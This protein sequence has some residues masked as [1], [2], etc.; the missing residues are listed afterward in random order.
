MLEEM[1]KKKPKEK[2]KDV[3]MGMLRGVPMG[4]SSRN[5]TNPPKAYSYVECAKGGFVTNLCI[6]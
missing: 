6:L 5:V 1:P 4:R 2:P 3:P